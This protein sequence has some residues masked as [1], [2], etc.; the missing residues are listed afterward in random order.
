[1]DG[2]L[3]T[4]KFRNWNNTSIPCILN[5]LNKLPFPIQLNFY[6]ALERLHYSIEFEKDF[7]FNLLSVDKISF[8]FLAWKITNGP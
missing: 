2:P 3:A 1:M 6:L 5:I 4:V 8:E 7:L